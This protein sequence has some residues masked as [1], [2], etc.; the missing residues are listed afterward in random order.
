MSRNTADQK[1]GPG[2]GQ[3]PGMAAHIK[4]LL[5]LTSI[6]FINFM[7]RI[8]QAPLMPIIEEQLQIS[9]AA[10]GSLFLTISIGYFI[11]LVGSSFIC[12]FLSHRRMILLSVSVLGLALIAT[13][14]STGLW[15]LRF[16]L[17]GLGLAAG[18]YLPSGIA[19]LTSM[20]DHRHWGKA[21]AIHE[22]APN[23]SFISAPMVAEIILALFSWR[24]AFAVLGVAALSLA[25]VF[26]RFGRGGDFRGEAPGIASFRKMVG[27]PSFWILVVLFGLG[28]SG[29]LGL[30]TM[31][32]LYLITDHGID[33]NWA[34]TLISL[35]RFSGLVMAFAGGW[36]VDRFGTRRVLQSVF[37]LNGA[38]TIGLG[39]APDNWVL[40]FVFV[41]PMVAVCFFPAGLAALSR[42][43]PPNLRNVAV[44]LVSPMGFLAGGGLMP[45]AIGIA[46][47]LSSFSLGIAGVGLLMCGGAFL[48]GFL[49]YYD[50]TTAGGDAQEEP[51]GV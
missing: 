15:G 16:S 22:I 35:S 36:A 25:A 19:T 3:D 32:P 30:F 40:L 1:A 29:T 9:H 5:L 14:A 31:L 28:I 10:A 27:R 7:A 51:A 47:D 20:I 23:L 11:S 6:F 38:V 44:S 48:P 18:L 8:I 45:A 46:G 2:S 4:P 24:L 37:L 13:S 50:Q 39:L 12:A 42:V 33:R 49:T 34:N 17:L 41:Q 26:L 43:S 21:I